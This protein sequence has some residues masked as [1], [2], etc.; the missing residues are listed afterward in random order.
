M[1]KHADV[2]RAP[3]NLGENV[4]NRVVTRCKLNGEKWRFYGNNQC[5]AMNWRGRLLRSTL[6]K[7]LFGRL[8]DL[9]QQHTAEL[10]FVLLHPFSS[11]I[12]LR[13]LPSCLWQEIVLVVFFGL[14]Y[15]IR[16][17]S[18]GCR[19]KYVGVWGR[20][21]FARK[22]ISI[23]GGKTIPSSTRERLYIQQMSH[24]RCKPAL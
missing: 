4:K 6:L 15:F 17:W 16:L 8:T 14:E 11:L 18:A 19:S 3:L 1:C 24:C 20:L 10:L 5:S 2:S 9:L 12:R 22:P 13:L 7:Q 23:I 21:R